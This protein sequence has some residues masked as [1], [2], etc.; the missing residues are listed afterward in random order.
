MV[1][2]R[3]GSVGVAGVLVLA[4]A[5]IFVVMSVIMVMY[6]LAWAG[7]MSW[8]FMQGTKN[9]PNEASASRVNGN[10]E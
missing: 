2:H 6:T 3:L 8:F 5:S 10:G 1:Q 4:C 7:S 9:S